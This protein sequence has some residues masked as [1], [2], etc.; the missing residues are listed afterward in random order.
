[1]DSLLEIG[2]EGHVLGRYI[3][4]IIL[5]ERR[6]QRRTCGTREHTVHVCEVPFDVHRL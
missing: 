2:W 3:I 4:G 1:M 5:L 6:G